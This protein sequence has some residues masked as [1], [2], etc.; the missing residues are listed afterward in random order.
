MNGADAYRLYVP[1]PLGGNV[2]YF[3]DGKSFLVTRRLVSWD[4]DP[5]ELWENL[6]EN[7]VNS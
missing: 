6:V 1:L 5:K 2:T 3:V 7:Y 4:G